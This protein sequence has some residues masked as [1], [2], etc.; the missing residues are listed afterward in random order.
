MLFFVIHSYIRWFQ[1]DVSTEEAD[2]MLSGRPPGTFMIRLESGLFQYACSYI[3]PHGF[4]GQVRH[5]FIKK[6]PSGY[7]I[8]TAKVRLSLP[9]PPR[10]FPTLPN[11]L[12][13]C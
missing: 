13:L 5:V 1:G 8:E 9:N 11:A 4:K 7:V 3:A 10:P 12:N 2:A 6:V